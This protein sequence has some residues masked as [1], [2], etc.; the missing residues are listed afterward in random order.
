V[1][2]IATDDPEINVSRVE[3][4]LKSGGHGVDP[5]KVRERYKRS[6][7]LL[8]DAIITSDRA[9]IFDNS[10]IPGG[11]VWLAEITNRP[12]CR[13]GSTTP[14]SRSSAF[15]RL[16]CSD[17][18]PPWNPLHNKHEFYLFLTAL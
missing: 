12:N 18:I 8:A 7:D 3:A 17:W 4:R 13:T 2:Y 9:F 6:L 16:T 5:V 15:N 14:C 10:G 1:Y 11:H